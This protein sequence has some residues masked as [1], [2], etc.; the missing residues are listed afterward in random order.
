MKRDEDEIILVRIVLS[1]VGD[2]ESAF[3]QRKGAGWRRRRGGK[4]TGE[5]KPADMTN[6]PSASQWVQGMSRK[7]GWETKRKREKNRH[8]KTTK[9]TQEVLEGGGVGV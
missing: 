7:S 8:I 6:Q 5:L 1:E 4:A 9:N 2:R 3:P